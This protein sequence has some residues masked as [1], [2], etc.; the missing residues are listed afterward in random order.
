[1]DKHLNVFSA[2]LVG[3]ILL[4]VAAVGISASAANGQ[5]PSAPAPKTAPQ[6][7]STADLS[8]LLEQMR[9][10]ARDENAANAATLAGA[11]RGAIDIATA[12]MKHT[13]TTMS[14]VSWA[15]GIAVATITI[16]TAGGVGTVL[17][18]QHGVLAEANKKLEE[19]KASSDRIKKIEKGATET[20]GRIIEFDNMIH[21][22]LQDTDKYSESLPK[23]ESIGVL[24]N[25]PE[26]PPADTAMQME[27]ADILTVV[28]EK[29]SPPREPKALAPAFLSL[30]R[31]WRQIG[32]YARAIARFRKA[33]KLDPD[34]WEAFEGLA[35]SYLE[36]SYR[37]RIAA[38]AKER[39]LNLADDAC[40]A[41]LKAGGKQAKTL[42]DQAAIA[43]QRK[44]YPDAINLYKE[45]Q[46][47]DPEGKVLMAVYNL[48][49]IYAAESE[50]KNYRNALDELKK[51]IKQDKVCESIAGDSDFD[52]L[53]ADPQ[54]K[55]E[56][57]TMMKA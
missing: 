6:A 7:L 43:D 32:D 19:A 2:S 26:I 52:G 36:L 51:I 55:D 39:L 18:G 23:V 1:M 21:S 15:T 50:F 28:G 47:L 46:S 8:S 48:A 33:T 44:N 25:P 35:R 37:S 17:Y 9:Q 54:F 12:A 41:A 30:G 14:V 10:I 27:E 49:C 20:A 22:A 3:A 56:Y 29:F 11:E 53:R 42:C 34:C 31:Y 57:E 45:A 13:D 38:D 4:T 16:I 24:G 40:T 5:T